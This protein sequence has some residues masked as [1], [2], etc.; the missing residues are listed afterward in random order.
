MDYKT[1]VAVWL[2]TIVTTVAEVYAFYVG[3]GTFDVD[4]AIGTVAMINSLVA[5]IFMM[6][7]RKEPPAVQYLILAPLALVMVLILTMLFAFA[8]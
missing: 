8:Q 3:P 6:N 7:I 2:Y 4:M 5:A 1:P